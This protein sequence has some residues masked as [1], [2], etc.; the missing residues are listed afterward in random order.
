MGVSKACPAAIMCS[1]SR[2]PVISQH[3]NEIAVKFTLP[4]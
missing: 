1:R 3:P 2:V 4:T